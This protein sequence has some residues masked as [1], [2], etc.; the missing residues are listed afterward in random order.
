MQISARIFSKTSAI[1]IPLQNPSRIEKIY[2]EDI[3]LRK[4]SAISLTSMLE[5]ITINA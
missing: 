1:K 2:F 5:S 3:I 4:F